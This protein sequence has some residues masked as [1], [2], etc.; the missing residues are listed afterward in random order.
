MVIKMAKRK[1]WIDAG[2]IGASELP[3]K[4]LKDLSRD[5][6]KVPKSP[7]VERKTDRR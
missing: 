6:R 1:V 7:K 5:M 2:L 3:S 4:E